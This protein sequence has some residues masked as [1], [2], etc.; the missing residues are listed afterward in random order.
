MAKP[1]TLNGDAVPSRLQASR[2]ED[3]IMKK[4]RAAKQCKMRTRSSHVI[5]ARVAFINSLSLGLALKLW[6]VV[7]SERST[8]AGWP[9]VA[10]WPRC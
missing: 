1:N 4:G 2:K 6:H 3:S 5:D 7:W 9:K 8:D 10:K